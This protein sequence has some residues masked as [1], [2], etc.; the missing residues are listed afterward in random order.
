MRDNAVRK[1]PPVLVI[2]SGAATRTTMGR[3]TVYNQSYCVC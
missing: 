2:V 1:I 3:V